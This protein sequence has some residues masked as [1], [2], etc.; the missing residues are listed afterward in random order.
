M[1][2]KKPVEPLNSNSMSNE[3]PSLRRSGAVARILRMPVASLRNWERR[4]ALTQ[5]KFSEGG[6]RLYSDDDVRRLA[7]IKQLTELGHAIGSLA[8]LDMSELQHV[9]AMLA[10]AQ[11]VAQGTGRTEVFGIASSRSWRIAVIGVGLGVRL[12]RPSLLKSLG[13]PIQLLGPFATIGQAVNNLRPEDIDILL[14]YESQLHSSW[15]ETLEALAPSFA[16]LPKAVLY[17]FASEAVCESLAKVGISLL[18]EP[19]PDIVLSQWLQSLAP[20]MITSQASHAAAE[21]S[22]EEPLHRWDDDVLMD[23]ASRSSTVSCECPRHVAELLVQLTHFE[24]YSAECANHNAADAQLHVFLQKMATESRARFEAAL[25][26]I[27]LHEGL[28]LPAES[29]NRRSSSL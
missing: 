23:F 3:I 19:Q 20:R 8:K 14:I 7:M 12:Q 22:S 5:A 25:E 13:R 11:A 2:E 16:G 26:R 1:S 27:A 9:G 24:R 15:L 17:G 4:Y 10:H 28:L 21:S 6:Q 29:Q 18:R